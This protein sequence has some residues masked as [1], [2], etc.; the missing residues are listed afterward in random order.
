MTIDKNTLSDIKNSL[1]KEK[2][3]LEENLRRIAKPIN[4]QKGDYETTFDDIGS[5]REDNAT[6]VEEYTDNLPVEITLEKKLQDIIAALE[7]IEKG[8]FG[9]CEKCK[10]EIDIERLKANPSAKTCIS[11]N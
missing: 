8:T 1:L 6:E 5:D 10:Q 11:C 9:V 4:T 2:K 7:K 3:E